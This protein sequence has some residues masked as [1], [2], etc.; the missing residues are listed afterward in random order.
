MCHQSAQQLIALRRIA[1]VTGAIERVKPGVD[2]IRRIADVMQP[3]GSDQQ[4]CV[5]AKDGF[6]CPRL[7]GDALRVS[8]PAGQRRLKDRAGGAFRPVS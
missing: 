2:E 3:S 7:R 8:P 6:E 4:V 5:V 1:Q